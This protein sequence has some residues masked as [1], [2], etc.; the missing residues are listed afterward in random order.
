MIP[1]DVTGRGFRALEGLLF[2]DGNER[3]VDSL[4]VGEA[5]KHVPAVVGVIVHEHHTCRAR[6]LTNHKVN[7]GLGFVVARRHAVAVAGVL[8]F[9][10]GQID[11]LHWVAQG[12]VPLFLSDFSDVRVGF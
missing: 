11:D 12:L 2:R 4:A 6:P 7:E 8:D 10:T 9:G 3:L 1:V 5:R